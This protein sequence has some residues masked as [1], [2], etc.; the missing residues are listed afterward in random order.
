MAILRKISKNSQMSTR[1]QLVET[2]SGMF[3][4]V[5]DSSLTNKMKNLFASNE[6]FT[7][8]D[9]GEMSVSLEKF[10][11]GLSSHVSQLV[12]SS[13]IKPEDTQREM[14]SYAASIKAGAYAAMGCASVES[15]KAWGS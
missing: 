13:K 11:Q 6:S 2:I 4:Q 7:E 3:S 8:S 10:E 5:T 12:A 14:D 9:I 1:Q 15:Y